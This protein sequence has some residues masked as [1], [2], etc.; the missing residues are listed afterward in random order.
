[1]RKSNFSNQEINKKVNQMRFML[2]N[3]NKVA[4]KKTKL[5]KVRKSKN[6]E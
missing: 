5:M 4:K 6:Q 1:M 3:W 2:L